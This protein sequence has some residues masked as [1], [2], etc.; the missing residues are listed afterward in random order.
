MRTIKFRA[1]DPFKRLMLEDYKHDWIKHYP[2]LQ[3]GERLHPR[4][5]AIGTLNETLMQSTA[6]NDCLGKEIF[7]GDIIQWGIHQG[8]VKCAHNGTWIFGDD[9]GL[10][11][12][13][14]TARIIGNIYENPEL[15]SYSPRIH[16]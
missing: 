4:V 12:P 15:I 14:L 5:W 2:D 6:L 11:P 1:W 8:V 16:P 7:E 3:I 10:F 9:F 13:N